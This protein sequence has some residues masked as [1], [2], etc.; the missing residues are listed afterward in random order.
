MTIKDA[1]SMYNSLFVLSPIEVSNTC[2]LV[3]LLSVGILIMLCLFELFVSW[4]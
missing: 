3:C 2:T 4:I 1:G